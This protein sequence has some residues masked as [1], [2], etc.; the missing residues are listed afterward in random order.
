M[1]LVVQKQKIGGLNGI[2][3]FSS[4]GLNKRAFN[5]M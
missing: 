1:K 5:E 3:V 2:M 4:S